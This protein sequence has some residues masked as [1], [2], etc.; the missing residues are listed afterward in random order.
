MIFLK[1]FIELVPCLAMG[2]C[3][4]RFTPG[5]SL[6]IAQFLINLGIPLS[7]MGLLL[8]GGLDWELL[9]AVGLALL[10]ITLLMLLILLTSNL[11]SKRF[12]PTLFLGSSFG[13]SGYFGIPISLALLPPQ[14]LGYS[15]GYDLGATLFIW[16]FG[17]TLLARSTN[18]L[19]F[20]QEAL[21][22]LKALFSS[23]ASKGLL[24]ALF[25]KLTP[26]TDQ[27]SIALWIPSRIT[28]VL[29]VLVVGMRLCW[30][31]S[32]NQSPFSFFLPIIKNTLLLKLFVLPMLMLLLSYLFGLSALLRNALVLQ[33]A[34]PTAIS[35]LLLSEAYREGQELSSALVVC[36]TV[37]SLITI[38]MWSVFLQF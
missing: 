15:I 9:K 7:L 17:P 27:I 31:T 25:V 29:A 14:A 26:W 5:L 6:R 34:T 1:L 20:K 18:E 4:G 22:F 19:G 13:N 36:S 33:A 24:A 23:P 32:A 37:F 8:K 16:S 11:G 35:V 38:P 21:T 3:L 2:Y 30:L 28:I 12:N 10:A